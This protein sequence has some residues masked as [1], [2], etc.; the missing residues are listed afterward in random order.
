MVLFETRLDRKA[1]KRV[2]KLSKR[3]VI[4]D[5]IISPE[6]LNAVAVTAEVAN[7]DSQN[8]DRLGFLS[9]WFGSTKEQKEEGGKRTSKGEVDMTPLSD[10]DWIRHEAEFKT[11]SSLK[12]LFNRVEKLTER[13]DL[14]KQEEAAKKKSHKER[15]SELKLKLANKPSTMKSLESKNKMRMEELK[16]KYYKSLSEVQ[17]RFT[18]VNSK[19]RQV[20]DEISALDDS[21]DKAEAVL[22]NIQ[23]KNG[24][25]LR[26]E[27][28]MEAYI[29]RED[30]KYKATQEKFMKWMDRFE[31]KIRVDA[32]QEEVLDNKW[33]DRIEK[34][35]AQIE[36]M[37]E[38]I[39]DTVCAQKEKLKG[40][41]S[42]EIAKYQ[43]EV[44]YFD[45]KLREVKE[46]SEANVNDL[47][48]EFKRLQKENNERKSQEMYLEGMIYLKQEWEFT[49]RKIKCGKDYRDDAEIQ[50]QLDALAKA[51]KEKE[52]QLKAKYNIID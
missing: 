36:D 13:L 27:K 48:M 3:H 40:H 45:G 33:L 32:E 11:F 26:L 49:S 41:Y 31:E 35:Q 9:K 14:A 38:R 47:V 34:L 52:D 25:I 51:F 50:K 16:S 23:Q 44:D 8:P 18:D 37:D 10:I 28:S 20:R 24:Q 4:S 15:L 46:I 29:L 39:S 12:H 6:V 30:Q 17:A 22:E 43:E 19:L 7:V 42:Q 2:E 5:K 21:R 1:K